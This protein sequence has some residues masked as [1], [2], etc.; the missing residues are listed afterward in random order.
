[1]ARNDYKFTERWNRLS[2]E[3]QLAE[4]GYSSEQDFHLE[5]AGRQVERLIGFNLNRVTGSAVTEA[6]IVRATAQ[7]AAAVL[8]RGEETLRVDTLPPF[9]LIPSA[10]QPGVLLITPALAK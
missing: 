6:P 3:E 9:A 5:Q 10:Q 4:M 8:G 1:M 7:Y 2:P